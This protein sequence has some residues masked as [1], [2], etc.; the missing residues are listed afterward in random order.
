MAGFI[1]YCNEER[2]HESLDNVTPAD[3][4]FRRAEPIFSAREEPK[5]RTP[6]AHRRLTRQGTPRGQATASHG[7][8]QA[9]SVP[10]LRITPC[11]IWSEPIQLAEKGPVLK[12]R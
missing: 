2:Y 5:Q 12:K 11:P 9:G 3:V 10:K 1:H 8:D 7:Y 6:A 4:Y